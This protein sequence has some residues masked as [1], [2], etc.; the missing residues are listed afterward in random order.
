[1]PSI[2]GIKQTLATTLSAQAFTLPIMIS[3][4]GY[5]SLV[6]LVTNILVLP[7]MPF[8]LGFGALFLFVGSLFGTIGGFL[9]SLPLVWLLS[10][11]FWVVDFFADIPFAVLQFSGT[12]LLIP[13]FIAVPLAFAAWKLR[14]RS[15]FLPYE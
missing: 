13:I 10:Y 15:E 2:L 3:N 8:L 5:F 12:G 6:S 7:L 14:R 1:M 4:F 11:F 9:L